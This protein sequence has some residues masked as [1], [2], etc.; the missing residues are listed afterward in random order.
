[1][2]KAKVI[3]ET[4]IN[5]VQLKAELEKIQKRDGELNFR[6]QRTDEYLSQFVKIT[7]KQASE[8]YKQIEELNIPR[9]KDFHIHKIIDVMPTTVD[10]LKVLLQGYTIT[11]KQENLKKITDLVGEAL[12]KK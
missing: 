7:P 3:S 4:S 1:M 11:V 6:S 12:G 8:L 9:L 10:D 5:I 2:S